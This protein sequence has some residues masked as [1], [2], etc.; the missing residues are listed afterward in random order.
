MVDVVKADIFSR[1][2]NLVN[3]KHNFLSNNAKIYWFQLVSCTTA[4]ILSLM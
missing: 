4:L 3:L 1:S 2:R